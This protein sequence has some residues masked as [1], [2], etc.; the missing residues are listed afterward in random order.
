MS[1]RLTH[2]VE[3]KLAVAD[4]AA[5]CRRLRTLGARPGPR[6]HEANLLFDTPNESLRRQEMLLRVRME[7]PARRMVH[8][9]T[10]EERIALL[11]SCMFPARRRQ[12]A[13][14]T[15]KGPPSI[16]GAADGVEQ[17]AGGASHANYKIRREIEFEISD[18]RS[19]RELLAALGFRPAFYYEKLRTTYRVPRFRQLVLTLDETPAGTYLELEGPPAAIDRARQ[20]L[21]YRPEDAILLS[22]G[23]LFAAHRRAAGLPMTDMLF[24]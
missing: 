11:E 4:R 16:R 1:H 22:Y 14:V 19:F 7:R 18:G 24:L 12:S 10:R 6:L 3:I 21:G 2:E 15:F 20:A 17:P 8:S 9:K 23:A 5:M 13:L